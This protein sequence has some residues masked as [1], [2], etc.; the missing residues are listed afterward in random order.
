MKTKRENALF[1]CA[2]LQKTLNKYDYTTMLS[3][4]KL[5]KEFI[6]LPVKK[7]DNQTLTLW[8]N[9]LTTYKNN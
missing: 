8:R 6:Y 7:T 2:V 9:L 1:I 4:D 3:G 5:K